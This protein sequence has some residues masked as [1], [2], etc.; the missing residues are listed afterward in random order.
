MDI[1]VSPQPGDIAHVQLFDPA[2][3]TITMFVP[4]ADLKG[5]DVTQGHYRAEVIKRAKANLQ[6]AIAAFPS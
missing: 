4:D 5:D 2:F 6:A 1:N 3:H